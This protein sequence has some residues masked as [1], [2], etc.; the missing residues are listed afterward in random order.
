MLQISFGQDRRRE[1]STDPRNDCAKTDV[2]VVEAIRL[3]AQQ[4]SDDLG[5]PL[6]DKFDEHLDL[7]AQH[8]K[9]PL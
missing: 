5:L 9:T 4:M 7:I 8:L 1:V 2:E 3:F 6:H